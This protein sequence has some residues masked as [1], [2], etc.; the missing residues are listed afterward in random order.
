MEVCLKKKIPQIFKVTS[1]K[2]AAFTQGLNQTNRPKE[3][4]LSLWLQSE[5]YQFSVYSH[6]SQLLVGGEGSWWNRLDAILLQA[7]VK[8]TAAETLSR[9]KNNSDKKKKGSAAEKN[10]HLRHGLGQV[11]GD[12]CQAPPTTVHDV[13]TAGAHGGAGTRCQAAGLHEGAA[14]TVSCQDGGGGSNF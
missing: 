8:A 5:S 14:A 13:V 4:Q 6:P 9:K 2:K 11:G 12:S 10:S 1:S 3:N 7:T